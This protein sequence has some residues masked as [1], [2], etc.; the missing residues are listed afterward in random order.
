MMW[1]LVDL[2][3]LRV[4]H[5]LPLHLK[6]AVEPFLTRERGSLV[7]VNRLLNNPGQKIGTQGLA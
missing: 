6:L 3:P 7:S 1:I 4:Q 5:S 2:F